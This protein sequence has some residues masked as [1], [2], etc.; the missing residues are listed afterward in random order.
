MVSTRRKILFIT[1]SYPPSTTGGAI[2]RK[3][4]VDSLKEDHDVIVISIG[5]PNYNI[6]GEIRIINILNERLGFILQRL[7]LISDYLILWKLK[8]FKYLNYNSIKI[9][10]IISTSGG[11]LG[12]IQLGNLLGNS[13]KV[14]HLIHLRDPIIYSLVNNLRINSK[15][16]VSR[17]YWEKK[18]YLKADNI[19]TTSR[20]NLESIKLKFPEVQNKLHFSP[21][22]YVN[23]IKIFN[24]EKYNEQTINIVY[25]G[26][27]GALQKPEKFLKF[28]K[29]FSNVKIYFFGD[30]NLKVKSENVVV[31]DKLPKKEFERFLNERIHVGLVSLTSEYLGA[32]IPA[33]LF[34]YIGLE[35]PIIGILPDGDAKE[36]IINNNF[37]IV[38]DDSTELELNNFLCNKHLLE[39]SNN[40]S[41]HKD[42]FSMSQ[43]IG[44][45]KKIINE[46]KN[47]L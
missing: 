29:R 1:R 39:I 17:E 23:T 36:I 19:V 12:T 43:N 6:K 31:L 46:G 7:G 45:I 47:K 38:V 4:M 3:F 40:I 21:I 35:I 44:I 9:D 26:N 13:F 32:C 11:E 20:V 30:F 2:M 28:F 15:F 18:E 10:Y 5:K 34:E 22:G 16:H 37:G 24:K 42:K 25:G 27:S 14:P 41:L 8:S 33:K